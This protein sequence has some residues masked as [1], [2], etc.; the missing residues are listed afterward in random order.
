MSASFQDRLRG[1]FYSL[2]SW[3]QLTEFWPKIDRSA[4]WFI[5]AVGEPVPTTPA[6]REALDSFILAIDALLR[7]DHDEDYCGIV[8]ADDLEHPTLIKIYDPNNLGV[9]CGSSKNPPL[10][11]WILSQQAP[12]PLQTLRVVPEN[13]KRW[14]HALGLGGPR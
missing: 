13:R 5:Y 9:S 7:K 8:F 6:E 3:Q 14:W 2:L 10:P 4:P 1:V 12:T 11:G